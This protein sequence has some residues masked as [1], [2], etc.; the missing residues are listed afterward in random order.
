MASALNHPNILAVYDTG[1]N[2]GSPYIVTELLEGLTLRE[3]LAL[4]GLGTRK[5]VEYAVQVARGMA[6]AHE[7]G[8]VNRTS[9]PKTCS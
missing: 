7:R 4:G 5:T 8:I 2:E 3:R 9:S 1:E 6:A